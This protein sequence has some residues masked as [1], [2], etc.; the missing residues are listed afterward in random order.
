[1]TNDLSKRDVVRMEPMSMWVVLNNM[2]AL[3]APVCAVHNTAERI[4]AQWNYNGLYKPYRVAR[5]LLTEI[6]EEG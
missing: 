5:V 2:G 4:C 6:E 1:M 3:A